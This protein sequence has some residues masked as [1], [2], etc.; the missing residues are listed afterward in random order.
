MSTKSKRLAVVQ[1]DR[2]LAGFKAAG[3]P[4][5]DKGW[6]RAIRAALGMSAKQLGRRASMTQAAVA[7]IEASETQ[8]RAGLNTL[9]KMAGALDCTL[10]YAL[11]PNT[12]L[13]DTLKGRAVEIAKRR[14]GETSHSTSPEEQDAPLKQKQIDILVDDMLVNRYKWFWDSDDA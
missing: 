5:P 2:T 8:G 4:V 14:L 1:L 13:E 3:L 6:I 9:K 10:V 7:Q 11:V 12:S